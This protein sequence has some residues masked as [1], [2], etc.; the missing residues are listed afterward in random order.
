MLARVIQQEYQK[1][2]NAVRIAFFINSLE[3]GGAERV[4]STLAKE[5]AKD[6]DV[7]VFLFDGHRR[8]FDLGDIVVDLKLPSKKNLFLKIFQLLRRSVAIYKIQRKENF[9]VLI[10]FMESANIPA[11]LASFFGGWADRLKISIRQNP[12]VLSRLEKLFAKI[13]YINP[14]TLT[15][16]SYGSQ[17]ALTKL[18][19]RRIKLIHNPVPN[20]QQTAIDQN[21][22]YGR[23][24]LF[25]GRL[26]PVKRIQDIILA[27]SGAIGRLPS[28]LSLVIGGS[29]AE[30][31]RLRDL[32]MAL[33]LGQ[34]ILFLGAIKQ[35][36]PLIQNAECVVLASQ[37][38]GWPNVLMEAI[39]CHVRIISSDCQYG[40][41]EILEGV[42][43]SEFLFPVGE[44]QA[45]EKLLLKVASERV[46]SD[47]YKKNCDE[48]L[49]KF[50]LNKIIQ[51]WIN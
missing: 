2:E 28:D 16:N 7:K 23:Y 11:S 24:F 51:L 17:Q 31:R 3:M 10:S 8:A 13:L 15:T 50:Q 5:I 12:S 20:F 46:V 47:E 14:I 6:H 35:P 36:M 9:E 26:D 43:A 29:G 38:E 4:L 21:Y 32:A 33:G 1:V 41:R 42:G 40:P 30:E 19:G 49:S 27:F 22:Q 45:L 44:V 25:L 34:R 48:F 18:I 39:Q 37:T